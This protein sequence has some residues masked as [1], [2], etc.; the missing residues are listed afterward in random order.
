VAAIWLR[1]RR[2]FRSRWRG[3]LVVAL[4]AGVAGGAVL[5]AA[6]GAR[7]TH[8]ALERHLVAY[9][10]PDAW[11]HMSNGG[12]DNT[13]YARAI[14]AL[15][16]LP[17]VQAS[18]VTGLLSYCA[19]DAQNRPVSFLGPQA[20]QFLVNIDGR[21]GVDLHRPKVLAGRLPDPA[22]PR[23]V[24]VDTRAA[25]RFGV[26]PGG[27]IPIRVFS[28]WGVGDLA[29][30]HCDPRNLNP[31]QRGLPERREFRQILISCRSADCPRA[32]RV[33][34]RLYSRLRNGASLPSLAERYSDV[35][36]AKVTGGKLWDE[37]GTL[38]HAFERVAFRL[39]THE[40]SHPF[41]TRFGWH[42]VEPLTK[43]V[44]VGPLIRLRVVGVK[45]TTEPY[46]IG[47]V[48]LTRAFDQAYRLDM[49]YSDFVIPVKLR[50][51]AADLSAL[52]RATG[53]D[54]R[55]ETEDAAKIQRSLDHQAQALWLAAGFGTLFALVLLAP[56]LLR[57]AAL[58]AGAHP[59]LRALGMTR[60]QLLA[61]DV[62]RAVAIGAGA[63]CVAVVLAFA[64]SPLT[65]IGLARDLE[66][67]PGFALDVLVVALGAVGVLLLVVLA[68]AVASLQARTVRGDPAA[69]GGCPPAEALARW[70]LPPTAVSGVRLALTR[71][72]GTMAVPIGGTLLG[73]IASVAVVAV[74]L[75]FTASMDHLLSTPRLYGQNWD[76]R[77]NFTTPPAARIRAD[78]SISDAAE[79]SG[80]DIH[81]EGRPVHITAMDDI[82]GRIRPVVTEGRPPERV[83][84]ILLSSKLMNDLG[85][86]VGDSIDARDRHSTRMQVVGRGVLPESV[87]QEQR[88]AAAMTFQAYKRL[89]PHAQVFDFEARIAPGPNRQSTL[90]RLERLYAH[91]APGPPQTVAD[92]GGVRNL[93]VVVSA[94][95]AA[96]AA[97]A[98]AHTLV[99]AIR[100]RRRQLAVLKTLGFDRR[101]LLATVAWQATT[102][103]AIG[104]VVGLP[105]G[106]AAGRWTWYLFAQQIE[107]VPEPVIPLRL[108]LLVVPAAVLLANLVAALPA[109]SAAA[110]R[111]AVVLRAE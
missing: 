78:P 109:W 35:S 11:L 72:T 9:R 36:D 40:L 21:D 107:V 29:V 87:A 82:K 76:Y 86:H 69:R 89:N 18:A 61:V 81:L 91:P 32:K 33:I 54:A 10:F 30:F 27:V 3:W 12:P 111:A 8:S 51:G 55:P 60:R 73:A 97:A 50:H 13:T 2:E 75:T 14:G 65:P 1:F 34:D 83:N 7:R 110:T 92:F 22:R 74:A 79:G 19:R 26:R 45:A 4:L 77:T 47:T 80:A 24:L 48:T 28:G 99:T 58:A 100:R 70:G 90:A 85:V 71:S 56:A 95:L 105:L 57:L 104:L 20:V 49:R 108:V 39:R 66:P 17:D 59:T 15:R 67:N 16:S 62:A 41:R 25:R 38:V 98:L 31:A 64:F 68:G 23:D 37:R 53:T 46:P 84:E 103:A 102:F 106:V 42:I 44:P 101:Q 6:A 96:I 5:T 94:L 52:A 43:V 88:P 93:P 63:A